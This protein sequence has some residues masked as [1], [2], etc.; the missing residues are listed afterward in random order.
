MLLACW[1][2]TL[3]RDF[4][5]GDFKVIF[6]NQIPHHDRRRVRIGN[7]SNDDAPIDVDIHRIFQSG[8]DHGWPAAYFE[9]IFPGFSVKNIQHR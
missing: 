9:A 7:I 8:H 3:I 5:V 4:P 1:T 6:N 2:S